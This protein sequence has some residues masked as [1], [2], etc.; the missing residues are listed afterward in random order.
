MSTLRTQLAALIVRVTE[1][2]QLGPLQK[3]AAAPHLIASLLGLLGGIVEEVESINRRLGNG[4]D[5]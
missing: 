3:A 1:L 4:T 2:D 5:R